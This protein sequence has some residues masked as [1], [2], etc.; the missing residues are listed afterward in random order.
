[1]CGH[2]ADDLRIVP[3]ALEAAV[4]RE[5]I[6][7]RHHPAFHCPFDEAG[8]AGRGEIGQR[9]Q[10]DPPGMPVLGQ[11]AGAD[12]QQLA[13]M[14]AALATGH[15][16]VPG[17]VGD[18]ELV[19]LDERAEM[20][21]E[22]LLTRWIAMNHVASDTLLQCIT[23]V[24]EVWRQRTRTRRANASRPSTGRTVCRQRSDSRKQPGE[25]GRL[26]LFERQAMR[27]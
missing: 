1:M 23:A 20:P 18:L 10:A 16:V 24:T 25:S 2:R 12:D 11:L 21:F 17:A 19:G 8:Q 7:D 22:W 26:R 6:A 14:A 4:R 15:W 5:P 3:V 27:T 9:P 13:D